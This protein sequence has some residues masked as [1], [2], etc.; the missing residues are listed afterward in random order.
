MKEKERGNLSGSVEKT[1]EDT[2]KM[3][4]IVER[5]KKDSVLMMA[6]KVGWSCYRKKRPSK[7]EQKGD[8]FCRWKKCVEAGRWRE[9][10][11]APKGR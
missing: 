5:V 9:I 7:D 6:K 10:I 1:P 2:Q 4:S 11:E 8:F 3:E